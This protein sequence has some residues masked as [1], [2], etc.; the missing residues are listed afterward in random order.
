MYCVLYLD[1]SLHVCSQILFRNGAAVPDPQGDVLGIRTVQ[2]QR[3]EQIVTQMRHLPEQG[4]GR[5]SKVSDIWKWKIRFYSMSLD[6][7][8]Y[9]IGHINRS[10]VPTYI[11]PTYIVITTH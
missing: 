8:K 4:G 7:T 6:Y 10:A 3:P 1:I 5:H 9:Y 11:Q 2:A